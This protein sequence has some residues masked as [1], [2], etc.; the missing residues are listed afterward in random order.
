M[1]HTTTR[2]ANAQC[3]WC[4]ATKTAE[5]YRKKE[6][7]LPQSFG[8]FKHNLTLKWI[9]CD[10]CN[11]RFGETHDLLLARGTIDGF[12][13]YRL[14]RFPADEYKDLGARNLR[15]TRVAQGELQGAFLKW[16]PDPDRDELRAVFPPQLGFRREGEEV[17]I[18]FPLRSLPTMADIRERHFCADVASLGVGPAEQAQLRDHFGVGGGSIEV[19]REIAPAGWHSRMRMETRQSFGPEFFAAVAKIGLNYVASQL[20]SS[21]AFMPAFD[22]IRRFVLEGADPGPHWV[23]ADTRPIVASVADRIGHV[24]RTAWDEERHFLAVQVS[25]H[26]QRRYQVRL[27]EGAVS[28]GADFE[29]CHFF[30]LTTMSVST[31]Q[32]AAGE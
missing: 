22:R 10:E 11:S 28:S 24:V 18:W 25:F 16:E 13:R 17:R 1:R 26:H 8:L 5:H 29:R 31:V 6:H 15:E 27:T 32:P 2:E 20:G 3:I 14:A 7:V 12:D 30:D 4:R 19:E 21:V 9:V 23:G